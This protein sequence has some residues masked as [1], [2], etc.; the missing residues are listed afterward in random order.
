MQSTV[1]VSAAVESR[2]PAKGEAKEES[3]ETTTAN[4]FQDDQQSAIA[5]KRIVRLTP[6]EVEQRIQKITALANAA[7]TEDAQRLLDDLIA[8]CPQ[9]E[10][11][12]SL[13]ALQDALNKVKED[14]PAVS[15]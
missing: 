12:E 5:R 1:G 11:P 8:Q 6:A 14:K 15:E 3:S 13:A 9:C 4:L 2:A 7:L 10:L